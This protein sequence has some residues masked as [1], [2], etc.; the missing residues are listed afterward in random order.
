MTIVHISPAPTD[1]VT[2]VA[3][4][5]CGSSLLVAGWSGELAL[6]SPVH[7]A[8]SSST[9]L[10]CPVLAAAFTSAAVCAGGLDGRVYVAEVGGSALARPTV[11]AASHAQATS[12]LAVLPDN[13]LVSGSWDGVVRLHDA[14][15]GGGRPDGEGIACD[16]RPGGKVYAL[17]T[18]GE[19]SLAMVTSVKRV[20]VVDRRKPSEF[21]YDILTSL[22]A[23]L[24]TVSAS[25]H[26]PVLVVGSTDGRV[27]VESMDSTMSPSFAFKCHRQ[28]G[29]A[30]PV[31]AVVHNRKYGSFATGGGD[32]H[33]SV[34][35]G[36]AKKRIYQYPCEATSISS[37]AFSPD[38]ARMAVAVSYTFEDGE[39]DTAPDAVLIRTLLDAEIRTRD[40]G[41]HL[42]AEKSPRPELAAA[43][44]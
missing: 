20:C 15:N 38:D 3:F 12:C 23:P 9:T 29:R 6:H 19:H 39:R 21:V 10:A 4:A 5:P 35:D 26:R 42:S 8:L 1:G 36:V 40:C 2:R 13:M 16:I 32:G 34:W 31:N 30:Y 17:D 37:I 27:A 24:R 18:V 43:P 28:D 25:P 7:G 11:L 22:N 14:R 33:V 41:V 44:S